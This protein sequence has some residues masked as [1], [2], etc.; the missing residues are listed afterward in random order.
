VLLAAIVTT[1]LVGQGQADNR[2]L[3]IG[4]TLLLKD[5][6]GRAKIKITADEQ[7]EA[8]LQLLNDEGEERFKLAA[9]SEAPP[10]MVFRE[11]SG[12]ARLIVAWTKEGPFLHL[13]DGEARER[14]LLGLDGNS[15]G[16]IALTDGKRVR[17]LFSLDDKGEPY[18][19]FMGENDKV[20]W[21]APGE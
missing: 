13:L 9:N 16:L 4:R 20:T 21:S 7:G 19:R 6:K 3:V 1:L 11:D 10:Y 18:I 17:A 14:L 5:D 12:T 8:F 15:N 2:G